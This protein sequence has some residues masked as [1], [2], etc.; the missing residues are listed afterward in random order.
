MQSCNNCKYLKEIDC[1]GY[2]CG[3]KCSKNKFNITQGDRIGDLTKYTCNDFEG[4]DKFKL[5]ELKKKVNFRRINKI[6]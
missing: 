4:N 2:I 6:K 1:L 3:Y 5:E